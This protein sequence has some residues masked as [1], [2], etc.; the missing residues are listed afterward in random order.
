MLKRSLSLDDI[1]NAEADCMKWRAKMRMLY[2]FD[3]IT[4]LPNFHNLIHV[5]LVAKR[6]GPSILYWTR[7]FGMCIVKTCY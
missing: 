3:S 1:T 5:P 4:D 6:W 7:P 2:E